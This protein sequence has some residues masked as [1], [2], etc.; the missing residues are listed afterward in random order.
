MGQFKPG[1]IGKIPLGKGGQE[2]IITPFV[3]GLDFGKRLAAQ[4]LQKGKGV[5]V[6]TLIHCFRRHGPL[7]VPWRHLR[8]QWR[9]RRVG[10][11]PDAAGDQGQKDFARTFRGSFDQA[12]ATCRG[13]DI[14]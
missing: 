5:L 11:I 6:H 7:L 8:G 3:A 9:A 13:F 10:I 14:V 4:V 2:P 1:T 12:S